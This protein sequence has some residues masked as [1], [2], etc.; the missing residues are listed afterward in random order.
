M[1]IWG[2]IT[3]LSCKEKHELVNETKKSSLN[4]DNLSQPENSGVNKY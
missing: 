2:E 3:K 4:R 1:Y